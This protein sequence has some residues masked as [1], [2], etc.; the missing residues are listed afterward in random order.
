MR[1]AGLRS[2]LIRWTEK[3]DG[4]AILTVQH[5]ITAATKRIPVTLVTGF[6]GSGKTTLINKALHAPEM[7]KV[8][9]VINE[10]GEVGLDHH[11]WLP[12]T[13]K[14]WCWKTVAC[15]AQCEVTSSERL[16]VFIMIG[17]QDVSLGST[18]L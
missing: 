7:S 12:A 4:G 14:S 2:I 8:V 1:L 3:E 16:T 10:Y 5:D 9:V 13:T 15:A 17:L 18:E 6:L 11:W